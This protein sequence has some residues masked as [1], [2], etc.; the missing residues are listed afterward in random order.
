MENWRRF[1]DEQDDRLI[2]EGKRKSF[3]SLIL[4]VDQGHLSCVTVAIAISEQGDRQITLF[5][6]QLNE[7]FLKNT[8][9]KFL[10]KATSFAMKKISD[11]AK[12]AKKVMPKNLEKVIVKMAQNF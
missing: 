2:V 6:K 7:N 12:L 8:A 3:E 5:E 1:Q 9:K 4:E 10:N 11:L